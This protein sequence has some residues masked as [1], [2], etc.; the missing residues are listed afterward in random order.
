MKFGRKPAVFTRR[1]LLSAFVMHRHLANLGPPPANSADYTTAVERAVG[2]PNNWGALGNDQY[3]DCVEADEGHYLMLRT[4]N[5]SSIV[6]PTTEQVLALY[7]A[8][9]GFNP[10]DPNTDQ[11]TDETGDCQYMVSTGLLGHKASATGMVDPTNMALMRWCI[12]LFGACKIGLNVPQSAIDQFNAGQPWAQVPDDGGI[13]GGHDVPLVRY[14][15]DGSFDCITWGQ[16]QRI[17]P[18]FLAPSAGYLE[19]AHA[20]LFPDFITSTGNTPAGFNL[21]MLIA[22]LPLVEAPTPPQPVDWNSQRRRRKHHHH[23]HGQSTS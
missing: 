7:S 23:H 13:A 9:T 19:E 16:R 11:G 21:T 2:G 6:V 14:Y 22:D 15:A 4:A 20:L 1:T 12:Q 18:N 17:L 10:N 8:E 5:A 3:G